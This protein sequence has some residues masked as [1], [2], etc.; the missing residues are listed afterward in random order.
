L[1]GENSIKTL[2]SAYSSRYQ[3]VNIEEIGDILAQNDSKNLGRGSL[4]TIIYSKTN[5]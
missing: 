4:T 2:I 5:I 3:I 1:F